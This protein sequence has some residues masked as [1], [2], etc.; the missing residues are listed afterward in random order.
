MIH[1]G[2]LKLQTKILKKMFTVGNNG[3]LA[4]LL[5]CISRKNVFSIRQTYLNEVSGII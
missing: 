5:F 2:P 1:D 4:S 3:L